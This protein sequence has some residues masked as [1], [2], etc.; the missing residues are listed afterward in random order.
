MISMLSL[1]GIGI[2]YA[3]LTDSINVFGTASTGTV[4]F[5]NLEYTG[6]WVYKVWDMPIGPGTP[7]AWSDYV[8]DYSPVREIL[9]LKGDKE[10]IPTTSD[11]QVWAQGEGGDAELIS[12]AESRPLAEGYL[13]D[14]EVEF[15]N[16]MPGV[17]Y[18]ADLHFN[19]GSIPVKINKLEYDY[20]ADSLLEGLVDSGYIYGLMYTDT[21]KTVEIGTQIHPSERVSLELHISIP[22]DND[23]QGLTGSFTCYIDIIQWTDPC[24]PECNPDI[25]L[26]VN[27]GFEY[28]VVEHNSQWNIF[29]DGT[30]DLGWNVEW[31]V[32]DYPDLPDVANIELHRG[33]SGWLAYE[34]EQYTELDSDFDG[35][36]GSINNE[37]AS[38]RIYQDIPTVPGRSYRLSFAFSPRPGTDASQ[39]ILN[40]SWNDETVDILTADG[41][42]NTNTE[43]TF[44][45]Y[46]VTA[47]SE[48]TQVAFSDDGIP[49]S[50][51]TFLDAVSVKAI[52]E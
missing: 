41:T 3:G 21:G 9:I 39:N 36:D 51:G 34:G 16:L 4:Q 18:V 8:D 6:T 52:C 7:P 12:W 29:P 2:A 11:V 23:Y 33:V 38:V 44:H 25:E 40:V 48:T 45:E 43:W 42:G 28:P 10:V 17:N 32:D 24:K 20:R 1:A 19:I 30:T 37:P 26:I 14:V 22:Q 49:N 15:H 27:G 35:P 50:M 13:H 47:N 5:E 46:I 31:I